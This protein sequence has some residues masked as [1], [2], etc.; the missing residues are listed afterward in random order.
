MA[1]KT[2][3]VVCLIAGCTGSNGTSE[4]IEVR[5]ANELGVTSLVAERFVEAGNQVFTLTGLDAA[6]HEVARV[7]HEIGVIPGLS[8]SLAGADDLGSQLVIE[9]G[10]NSWRAV[11]RG[12]EATSIPMLEG[13]GYRS[14]F[15][16]T[17]VEAA[18]RAANIAVER[19]TS[20]E[21]AFDT[22]ACDPSQLLNT[23]AV[24]QCCSTTLSSG[25]TSTWF[26]PT[27]GGNANKAIRRDYSPY[28]PCKSSTGGSCSGSACY[29]GPNGYS[30]PQVWESSQSWNIN[31][32]T[33]SWTE[34]WEVFYETYCGANT[35]GGD[36]QFP[37][38]TGSLQ[39]QNCPGGNANDGSAWA[40]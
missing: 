16:L 22:D 15:R 24:A 30:V 6:E 18:L 28:G 35:E 4:S 14:F 23:M 20:T 40:Y 13:A 10:G 33:Y 11:S 19:S 36:V 32:Y 31:V 39:P 9:I 27:S 25:A 17:A 7:Q 8:A 29:Y 12:V 2:T 3:V 1:S 34:N 37:T 21:R 5:E 26:K 38:V